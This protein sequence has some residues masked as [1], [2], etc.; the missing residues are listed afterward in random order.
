MSR[1][2]AGVA[3]AVVSVALIGGP[4]AASARQGPDNIVEVQNT[5]DGSLRARSQAVVTH[6]PGGDVTNNNVATAT[7]SCVNCRTAAAAVQMLIVEGAYDQATFAPWNLGVAVNQNCDT[8]ETFAYAHQ[9]VFIVLRPVKIGARASDQIDSIQK[10]IDDVVRSRDDFPTMQAELD[11]LTD[12]MAGVVRSEIDRS[13]H[14]RGEQD[15]RD[16]HERE[17][18]H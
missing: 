17:G 8:C 18:Q 14:G 1:L 3:A 16:V 12:Q 7:S 9:I 11:S 4:G 10:D 13:G 5:R 2:R 15:H 6:S